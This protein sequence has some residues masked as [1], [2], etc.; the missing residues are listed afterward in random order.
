MEGHGPTSRTSSPLCAKLFACA[1]VENFS[2]CV[3]FVFCFI[4]V[5]L[6]S[7]HGNSE[8]KGLT[9]VHTDAVACVSWLHSFL[10]SL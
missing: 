1:L 5:C 8:A 7:L 9:W 3:G 2:V 6:F 4:F 10:Y